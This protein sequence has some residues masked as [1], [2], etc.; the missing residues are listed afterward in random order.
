MLETVDLQAIEPESKAGMRFLPTLGNAIKRFGLPRAVGA[1]LLG[2][3][4][5]YVIQNTADTE[6]NCRGQIIPNAVGRN[7]LEAGAEAY[8]RGL[9]A[10]VLLLDGPADSPAMLNFAREHQL[11][12]VDSIDVSL[13][14]PTTDQSILEEKAY[15]EGNSVHHLLNISSRNHLDRVTDRTGSRATQL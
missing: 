13:D 3:F 9:A 1:A 2:T 8:N 6:V 15:I 12:P 14:S 11:V 4:G 7:R 10:K 5:G